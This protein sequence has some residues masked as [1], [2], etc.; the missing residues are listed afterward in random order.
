MTLAVE[1]SIENAEFNGK[2]W[3]MCWL[4]FHDHPMIDLSIQ[5]N[6]AFKIPVGAVYDTDDKRN[7]TTGINYQGSMANQYLQKTVMVT[8]PDLLTG[9]GCP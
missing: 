9:E 1:A 7:K 3:F 6:C 8:V 5:L 2:L 4:M